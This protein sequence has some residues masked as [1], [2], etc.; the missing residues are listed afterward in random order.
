M[1]MQVEELISLVSNAVNGADNFTKGAVGFNGYGFVFKNLNCGIPYITSRGSGKAFGAGSHRYGVENFR[2]FYEL[3]SSIE[4]PE[5]GFR[6][7]FK[8]LKSP[9]SLDEFY[10]VDSKYDMLL[11]GSLKTLVP[12]LKFGGY[13]EFFKV[14]MFVKTPEGKLFPAKFYYG[15]SGLSIGGWRPD[16]NYIDF[17]EKVFP[18]NFEEILNFSPYDFTNFEKH[19]F[20]D[21]LE[22][23]LKKVPISDFWGIYTHDLGNS[24]MGV[25]KSKPFI[26]EMEDFET[27]PKAKKEIEPLL[28]K[29]FET[30]NGWPFTVYPIPNTYAYVIHF[31]NI[32][33]F[34]R[35]DLWFQGAKETLELIEDL[36][37]YTF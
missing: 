27:D 33:S 18:K 9:R 17:G 7:Q 21:A 37:K 36:Q 14:W 3:E 31:G 35:N 32:N 20:L 15:Q 8:R 28:G 19:L 10:T 6:K 29:T 12:S 25:E 13:E 4:K 5:D 24:F 34:S 1:Y 2:K 23:A 22:F 30:V 26:D 11:A 16:E